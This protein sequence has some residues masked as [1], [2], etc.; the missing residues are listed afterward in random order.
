MATR[1]SQLERE[2][3]EERGK[4]VGVFESQSK[5]TTIAVAMEP[6]GAF[7]LTVDR[8][9][10]RIHSFSANYEQPGVDGKP[11]HT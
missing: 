8:D 3:I 10:H 11:K 2:M 6:D 9:G 4:A 1:L 7:V 5:R